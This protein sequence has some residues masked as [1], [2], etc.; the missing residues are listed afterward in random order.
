MAVGFPVKDDYATGD[1]LT[2][3]NMNDLAGTV[4]TVNAPLGSA[5]G[6][7]AVI[8]GGLQ[9]WQRGTTGAGAT[10]A[11]TGFVADRWQVGR[12][13][14]A[15]GSTF[16]RQTTSDTTNLPF[17]QY[18]ARVQRDSGNTGTG[19][20][21]FTQSLESV[22]SIPLA[23]KSVTLS[24]YAR[25]GANFSAASDLLKVELATGTGTDQNYFTAG[26]TG[27]V[28]P[29][30]TTTTLTATWQRFTFTGTVPTTATEIAVQLGFTPVGTAGAADYFEVTGVQVEAGSIATPF[31]T[32][33]G[34]IQGELAACQRYYYR[35]TPIVGEGVLGGYARLGIGNAT[36][37]TGAAILVNLP[38]SMR[39]APG[40]TLDSG[41]LYLS[42]GVT[43]YLATAAVVAT[44]SKTT[45]VLTIT[46]ASGLTQYRS[47]VLTGT[48]VAPFVGVSA[49]L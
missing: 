49:E 21:L 17:I 12:T 3:A 26:Y 35:N 25:K 29:I 37:T 30:N 22:N 44:T 23:G 15:A 41:N 2:A 47:Y 48:G 11:G 27:T 42:D 13:G 24:F 7:N 18:C 1:V 39:V 6:K 16:S 40:S 5:A 33:T 46:V 9:V 32:A 34:T 36:S 19:L 8:N 10:G 45:A 4:N 43:D 14:F 31:Q 20:V 28:R 38:V